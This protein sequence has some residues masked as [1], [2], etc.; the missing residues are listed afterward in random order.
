MLTFVDNVA[1]T[2]QSHSHSALRCPPSSP[3]SPLSTLRSAPFP[4]IFFAHS[5]A[6]AVASLMSPCS[7]SL[8]CSS[9]HVT[10]AWIR[11]PVSASYGELER[12][13]IRLQARYSCLIHEK[14]WDLDSVRLRPQDRVL[15]KARLAMRFPRHLQLGASASLSPILPASLAGAWQVLAKIPV[16]ELQVMVLSTFGL[17]DP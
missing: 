13:T 16:S 9:D 17:N 6:L 12:A 10:R 2:L 4:N 1:R 7:S 11:G 3:S 14:R 8:F 5:S 15:G